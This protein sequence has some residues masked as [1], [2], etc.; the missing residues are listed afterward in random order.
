MKN[1]GKNR[2]FRLEALSGFEPEYTDLQ[3]DH[4]SAFRPL[5]SDSLPL[6]LP[7]YV[8]L[9]YYRAV[10]ERDLDRALGFGLG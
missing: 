1:P 9:L 8:S 6:C 10:G 3:S 7:L 2:G 5:F 4:R